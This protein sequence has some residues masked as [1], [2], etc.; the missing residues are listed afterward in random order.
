MD[1]NKQ[2]IQF[3]KEGLSVARLKGGDPMIFGRCG[4][5]MAALNE[6][7]IPYEII[8][9]ISSAIAVPTY[10]GIPITH[11]EHSH[12]VAFVTATRADDIQNSDFPNADTLV[13]MMS[14]LRLSPLVSRL[15]ELRSQDTPIAIIASG[16]YADEK[17]VV[18]T[19]ETIEQMQADN[20]LLPPALIIV[21]NVVNLH[22]QFN[23]RDHLPLKSHRFVLFRSDHQQSKLRDLLSVAGAEVLALSLNQITYQ[24]Q[25][26]ESLDLGSFTHIVFTSEN[27]V[28]AFVKA[29]IGVTDL[30]QLANKT[31][32][33]IG[34][35]TSKTLLEFGL[36]A[37]L[38]PDQSTTSDLIEY[39]MPML[40]ASHHVLY[41][42]SSE[43]SNELLSLTQTG[44]KVVKC[45]AYKNDPPVDIEQYLDWIHSDDIFVFMNS[46]AVDRLATVYKKLNAHQSIS[47][48]PK[49]TESLK[50]MGVSKIYESD[51]ASIESVM[52]TIIKNKNNF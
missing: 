27:A 35:H 48:G 26:L 52:D 12:S 46:A 37:D 25:W 7:Q 11:R 4:E 15:K 24:D 5:E 42:T 43:A 28:R 29:I 44:A 38:V 21:G 41:P 9:G 34:T 1:I 16:T 32:I 40:S 13:I 2:L 8:P 6:C 49:T 30:R 20:Q 36:K 47:I 31:L 23:W 3:A 33:S 50:A 39:L 18:G 14:L 22:A 19:L 45:L 51:A 10:A 17:I